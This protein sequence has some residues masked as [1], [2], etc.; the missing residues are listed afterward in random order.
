[1]QSALQS[2]A[3]SLVTL[4]CKL[5]YSHRITS[6]SATVSELEAVAL[7]RSEELRIIEATSVKALKEFKAKIMDKVERERS[8]WKEKELVREREWRGKEK[9]WE[10]KLALAEQRVR[11][12]VLEKKRLRE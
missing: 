4:N 1:M 7:E 12:E 8:R 11:E 6:L 3:A 10:A 2:L 9:S 5:Q